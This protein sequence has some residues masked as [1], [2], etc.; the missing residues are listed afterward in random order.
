MPSPM[1]II[2]VPRHEEGLRRTFRY[3]RRH[4]ISDIDARLRKADDHRVNLALD[5]VGDFGLFLDEAFDEAL[6]Y[7]P[8]HTAESVGP[9]VGAEAWL[10]AM[11]ARTGATLAPQRRDPISPCP[12]PRPASFHHYDPN[13]PQRPPRAQNHPPTGSHPGG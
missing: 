1:P 13:A 5:R 12:N 8:L 4:Y 9:P 10:A 6:T 3:V 11:A 7:A 2:A